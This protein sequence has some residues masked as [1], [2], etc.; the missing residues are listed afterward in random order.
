M[1]TLGDNSSPKVDFGTKCNCEDGVTG[2]AGRPKAKL[3]GIPPQRGLTFRQ[4][5]SACK[6]KVHNLENRLDQIENHPAETPP[7]H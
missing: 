3:R 2:N 4:S 7:P 1:Q 6:K 5:V